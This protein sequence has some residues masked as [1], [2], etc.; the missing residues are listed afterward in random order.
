MTE[1]RQLNFTQHTPREEANRILN[2][3]L[4]EIEKQ[5]LVQQKNE[6]KKL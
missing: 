4:R 5:T 6:T 1:I 2:L 3:P